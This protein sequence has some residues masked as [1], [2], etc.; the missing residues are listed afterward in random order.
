MS[1]GK[2]FLTVV[3]TFAG[4]CQV[5]HDPQVVG[6]I[7]VTDWQYHGLICSQCLHELA[8]EVQRRSKGLT[9]EPAINP[10]KLTAVGGRN[11]H[12]R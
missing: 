9:V 5:C 3:D 7:A 12:S 8:D 11:G 6:R 10:E 1:G 2:R 4:Y